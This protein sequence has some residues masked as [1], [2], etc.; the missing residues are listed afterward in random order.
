MAEQS[1]V[2]KVQADVSKATNEVKALQ[3][4]IAKLSKSSSESNK[5][6]DSP[7]IKNASSNYKKVKQAIDDATDAQQRL[8]E[9]TARAED[10]TKRATYAGVALTQGFSDIGSFGMGAAQGIRAVANNA[11]QFTQALAGLKQKLNEG[12]SA[13]QAITGSLMGPNKF[14]FTLTL[15]IAAIELVSNLM[16][17]MGKDA[18]ETANALEGFFSVISQSGPSAEITFEDLKQ[19]QANFSDAAKETNDELKA[20]KDRLHDLRQLHGVLTPALREQLKAEKENAVERVKI[21]QDQKERY[22]A[23]T[24]SLSEQVDEQERIRQALIDLDAVQGR[25]NFN[26]NISA[27]YTDEL[28]KKTYELRVEIGKLT[29][30]RTNEMLALEL[31]NQA[32]E[33]ALSLKKAKE[34]IGVDPEKQAAFS[35]FMA[36][37]IL[38]G[39][40]DLKN[41]EEKFKKFFSD[42]KKAEEL[43]ADA[44]QKDTDEI[45]KKLER[46]EED[47]FKSDTTEADLLYYLEN[48]PILRYNALLLEMRED[49]ANRLRIQTEKLYKTQ[50]D[51]EGRPLGVELP[52]ITQEVLLGI[53]NDGELDTRRQKMLD[54]AEA[55]ASV[56][57]THAAALGG[58]GTAMMQMA[59]QGETVNRSQFETGKKFAIAQALVATYAGA[60]ESLKL[61]PIAGPIAAASVIAQ[62]M[63][64]VNA[65]R[66]M[67]PGSDSGGT[68]VAGMIR[69]GAGLTEFNVGNLYGGTP[70]IGSAAGFPS[71]SVGSMA[72]SGMQI[73]LVARGPDLVSAVDAQRSA[74]AR[75]IGGSR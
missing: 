75:L 59:K 11:Q 48:D 38:T 60:A 20:Q 68:S 40:E 47:Y 34:F 57:K 17:K 25:A 29:V 46:A 65:I 53:R 49:S 9:E 72:P 19:L 3:Q 61:G 22:D 70:G 27:L 41:I 45:K 62:G 31:Q 43:G 42:I 39:P 66:R 56:A 12:E 18:K 63:V 23:I 36:T 67:R 54:F 74:N 33:G 14:L 6:L 24:E 16:Q 7:E 13:F 5:N 37:G 55:S 8:N 4:A 64:Q 21:L 26:T 30:A 35:I 51:E 52:D 44:R 50:F 2:I 28:R 10:V 32:M 69:G 1:V 73:Q 58:I 15:A 71:L